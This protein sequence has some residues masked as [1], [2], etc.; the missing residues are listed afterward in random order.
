MTNFEQLEYFYLGCNSL[1]GRIPDLPTAS[2]KDANY[3]NQYCNF[4]S[5]ESSCIPFVS[6]YANS[7]DCATLPEGFSKKKSDD[8]DFLDDDHPFTPGT[9]CIVWCG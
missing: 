9:K 8:D 6:G 1:S 7:W 3:M 2:F 5:G 4:N